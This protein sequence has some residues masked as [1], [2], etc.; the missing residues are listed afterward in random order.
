MAAIEV[1]PGRTGMERT[2]TRVERLLTEKGA[3]LDAFSAPRSGHEMLALEER[4]HEL[5][6]EIADLLTLLDLVRAHQD[7]S[8]KK[9]AAADARGRFRARGF[10]GLIDNKGWERTTVYL[11]HGLKVT[12]RTPYLRPSRDGWSGRPRTKRGPAG[13][14]AF[15]VLEALGIEDG[16]TPALRSQIS[17]LVVQCSSFEEAHDQLERDGVSLGVPILVRVAIATGAKALDREAEALQGARTRELPL[18]ANSWLAGKRVRVSADGGRVRV[19]RRRKG[20]R[21]G[22]NGRRPFDLVWRE[23]RLITIDILNDDGKPD[24]TFAPVYLTSMDEAGDVIAQL[25]GAL[26]LLGANHAAVVEFVADGAPWMWTRIEVALH[27]A[28]VPSERVRLVLDYYHCCEHLSDAIKACKN[29]PETARTALYERLSRRLLDTDGPAEVLD[30]LRRLA[31]GRRA[32]A[33]NDQIDYIEGHLPHIRYADLRAEHLPI[34]SGV[35]ESGIRRIV[36][37]RF[38][39]AAT[40]WLEEHVTPLLH[41]RAILKSGRWDE[42]IHSYLDRRYYL[43]PADQDLSAPDHDTERRCA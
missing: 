36:N 37:L 19:R 3:E 33:I 1:N 15:P 25:V 17:R 12:L 21:K 29:L 35:V 40:F 27:D 30:L 5:S 6:G 2:L 34:G 18:E 20:A 26:R 28:G 7:S 23:P 43:E 24:P 8:F 42:F 9:Q 13:S 22:K 41:L 32:K 10:S 31:K 4:R 11:R 14:G 38:K 39:S 16:V